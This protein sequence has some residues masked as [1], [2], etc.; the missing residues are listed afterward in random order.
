MANSVKTDI[1]TCKLFWPFPIEMFYFVTQCIPNISVH[2]W[3]KV[4]QNNYPYQV[5]LCLLLLCW[6]LPTSGFTLSLKNTGPCRDCER[7]PKASSLVR[8]LVCRQE[9]GTKASLKEM[10]CSHLWGIYM[11]RFICIKITHQVHSPASW[12][13][14]RLSSIDL[15]VSLGCSMQV[16]RTEAVWVLLK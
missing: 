12:V 3:K 14:R 15:K 16:S 8:R 11:E 4:S 6:L 2:N 7:F 10:Y 1:G 13:P 9:I 5:A